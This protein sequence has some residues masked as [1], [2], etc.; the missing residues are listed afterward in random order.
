V[1]IAQSFTAGS[2][3]FV[4]RFS[5][6]GFL[7]VTLFALLWIGLWWQLSS[8][9]SVN[10]Q[11]S[12]GWF[13]PFFAIV[14]FWLRWKD[15][16]GAEIQNSKFKIQNWAAAV[17]ILALLLLFPIRLFEIGN[18]DWR[19]LSWLH[20]ICVVTITLAF[21]WSIGGMP[22]LRHFAFPVA[23]T[24][25]AVPWISPIEAPI[26]QGLMRMIAMVAAETAN[27]L[28]IPA[29]VQGNLIQIRTGLIG[30]N[31]ACSGVRS[32]QTSLMIGLL[33]GELKR[34]S[35]LRRVALVA[36]AI[37]IA[38]VANFFRAIL[39]VWVGEEEGTP[40]IERWHDVAGY[41]IVVLV[42]LGSL[43]LAWLLGR[44]KV[45]AQQKLERKKAK[46]END[47]KGEI[48][49]DKVENE[50]QGNFYFLLPTSYF[51]AAAV[52]WLIAVEF[53]AAGW[54]RAHERNVVATPRWAVKWP[55]EA[56]GFHESKIEEEVRG[57]LRFDSGH[58]AEWKLPALSATSEVRSATKPLI[59][60]LFF[61]RWKPGKNSALLTN[62]HRPDVCLPAIGWSQIADIGVKNYPV[63][64]NL[65]LP[66][67]HFEFHHGTNEQPSQQI[68]HAF[69]CLWEDRVPAS[70]ARSQLP[71]MTGA[72][73]AW[74]RD[75]RVQAVL[76]GRRHLG[77]Q[78]ME[79]IIQGR[80][81]VDEGE[82]ESQFAALLPS[83][84]QV[85]DR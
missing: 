36:G 49:K 48:G 23:F 70:E 42:F 1:T 47:S 68:A 2:T 20:A 75:E 3:P 7:I 51:A 18:P 9:W 10:D 52:L 61:F 40:A 84:I 45:R 59:C 22:W 38:F 15:A 74:T 69:Y 55:S 29:Q 85:E 16:P 13:V 28:G 25:V 21:L 64:P 32:L 77:Q 80:G 26:I 5:I 43:A 81:A 60:T 82:V 71:Q 37:A 31:E 34:L 46:G 35:I 66:F 78:V 12:Y 27:L 76:E 6:R 65:S 33:F 53:A 62:L 11:Y 63:T 41:G 24:L 54:Y 56:P 83:L 73:S 57:T 30:V 67:R 72:P 58:A 39:L 50:R 79:L 19:P 14:L 8:E 44:D 17:A 4:R